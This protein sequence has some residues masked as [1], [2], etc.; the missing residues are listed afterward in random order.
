MYSKCM[1]SK[2]MIEFDDESDT[3]YAKIVSRGKQIQ[4][5]F[6]HLREEYLA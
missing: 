3:K 1:E 5:H 6:D 4:D 2:K